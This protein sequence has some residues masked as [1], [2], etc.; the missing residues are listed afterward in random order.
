MYVCN[1]TTCNS[2]VSDQSLQSRFTQFKTYFTDNNIN[3][4]NMVSINQ[5]QLETKKSLIVF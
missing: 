2:G 4:A 3:S 5:T 1:M